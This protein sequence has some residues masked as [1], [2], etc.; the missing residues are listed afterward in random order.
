MTTATTT[1][2]YGEVSK[3]GDIREINR[4]IRREMSEAESKDQ[5]T[6]L[7]RRSDYLCTLTYAPTWQQ[8]FGRKT[9]RFRTAARQE[10]VKTTHA[11]NRYA[12]K[13]GFEPNYHAWHITPG[14]HDN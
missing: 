3:L 1:N 5:I 6:E 4:R 13:H 10:D 9:V 8:R 11:A 14:T 7:K 2:I 12:R